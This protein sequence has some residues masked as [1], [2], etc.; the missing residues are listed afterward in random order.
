MPGILLKELP[1]PDDSRL[2][3]DRETAH[4]LDRRIRSAMSTVT[5]IETLRVNFILKDAD[6]K[7]LVRL[8][9]TAA[10]FITGCEEY[11][12][13][14]E[15]G[16]GNPSLDAKELFAEC[17]NSAVTLSNRSVELNTAL[18]A[19]LRVPIENPAANDPSLGGPSI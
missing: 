5:G 4:S 16:S 17:Q 14:R 10:V 7:I 13:L 2:I 18:A 6:M 3:R 8:Q 19:Y 1:R 11:I 12:E 15:T 9:A